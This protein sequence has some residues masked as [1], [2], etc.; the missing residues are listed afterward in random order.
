MPKVT[1]E[2]DGLDETRKAY[3]RMARE[4]PHDL[5][6]LMV[7]LTDDM[8]RAG[9]R[10]ARR[11]VGADGARY[12]R[13]GSARTQRSGRS[14]VEMV[15]SKDPT[16]RGA[17]YGARRAWVFGQVM[18]ADKLSRRQFG[19]WSKHGKLYAAELTPKKIKRRDR[20]VA[21]T[22]MRT[23]VTKSLNRSGVPRG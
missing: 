4:A 9:D 22:F 21:D 20:T 13:P 15:L 23:N 14:D 1:H 8:V 11:R 7:D 2:V 18:S 6:V 5:Q 12:K 17:E 16:M 3:A 19:K 10:R